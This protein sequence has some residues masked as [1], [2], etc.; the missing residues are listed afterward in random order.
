MGE[1][2]CWTGTVDVVGL[3]P[4]ACGAGHGRLPGPYCGPRSLLTP[5]PPCRC[6]WAAGREV[7]VAPSPSSSPQTMRGP[8]DPSWPV[9]RRRDPHLP[10][11]VST[12]H[13]LLT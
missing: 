1:G 11:P 5:L 13:E 10:R 8:H 3:G 4:E 12:G 9:Y 6:C 2:R 7:R